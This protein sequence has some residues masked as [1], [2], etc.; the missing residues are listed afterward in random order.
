MA[1]IDNLFDYTDILSSSISENGTILF[2]TGNV[3]G[4]KVKSEGTEIWSPSGY[5][6]RPAKATTKDAAQ[7][8]CIVRGDQDVCIATRDI[9]GNSLQ[10]T[11]GDGEVQI[12]ASGP[13]NAGISKMVFNNDS[14]GNQKATITVNNTKIEI[15]SDGTVNINATTVN[16]DANTVNLSNATIPAAKSDVT[17]A[18]DNALLTMLGTALDSLGKPVTF[19]PS[20]LNSAAAT[21]VNIS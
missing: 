13:D 16:I 18:N 6:S 10:E 12:F 15:L 5:I 7:G 19:T 11:L 9:R 4:Q 14:N 17:D 2:Q 3:D 21:N 20:P 1:N 8:V